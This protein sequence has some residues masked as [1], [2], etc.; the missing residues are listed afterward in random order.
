[1]PEMISALHERAADFG[2]GVRFRGARSVAIGQRDEEG[3]TFDA[4]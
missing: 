1:M 3:L 4:L 2:A